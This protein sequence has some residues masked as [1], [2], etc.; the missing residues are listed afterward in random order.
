MEQLSKRFLTI[1]LAVASLAGVSLVVGLDASPAGAAAATLSF[2]HQPGGG[3]VNTGWASQPS[4]TITSGGSATDTIT[5]SITGS[6]A[7]VTLTC[8]G[9]DSKAAVASVAA[10]NG[11]A[12]NTAGTYTLTATDT[13]AGGPAQVSSPFTVFGPAHMLAFTT[14]P[15][16]GTVNLPLSTQPVVDVEDVGGNLVSSGAGSTDSITLS[17]TGSPAGVTLTC[18]DTGINGDTKAAVNGVAVFSGC[19][20]NA[21][22][23]DFTL[24]AT[25]ATN[26]SIIFTT[27]T[28]F[29]VSGASHLAFT[30]EP[31]NG[32]LGRPLFT[33][34]VVSLENASNAVV[35]SGTGSTD[36]V[37]LSITGSP[38][39]ATLTCAD[40]GINGDTKA[41]V[42]GVA[43]FSGC[44]IN[45]AGTNYTLT[46]TDTTNGV[47]TSATSTPFSVGITP[48]P[49]QISG[50]DAIGTAIAIS[51]AE[52]PNNG[53]AGG[54]VLAR[55]DFFSDALTGG[56]LAAAIN[57]PLLITPGA[58]L[59]ASLDP[60]VDAEIERVLPAGGT[61][62]V[63]GGDLALSPNIDSTLTGQGYNVIREA[64]VDEFATAVDVAEALGNPSTVFE[65]TG[66]SFYDALSAVPAAIEQ[67]AAILLTNGS[68][69][70]LETYFYLV[71]NPGDTRYAIGGPLAAYGADPSAI[72]VY[73]QDLFGTSAQVASTFFPKPSI[74]GAATAASFPDAL[75]GG[76]FMATGG[77]MGPLLLVNPRAPLPVEITPYLATLAVGTQAYVFGGLLAVGSDVLAALQAAVG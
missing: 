38:A 45:K 23:T 26:G 15:G 3:S 63:L 47:V 59:S 77:R 43:A 68:A 64:G 51:Q 16:N 53:S 5:L 56:P 6:P 24:T 61:V 21:A 8:T 17:I 4:V 72:P 11:C 44:S 32:A 41:A 48:Y 20:I 37:T 75:G 34:P 30:T 58:P 12:I 60:R 2:N 14:E 40:S 62:Y 57:G 35:T 39:G 69:E 70:S 67:H 19:S 33:Q 54:V 25:D 7:G 27:S 29:T 22:G 46:A 36:S 10:F 52:F 74:F 49:I 50:P 18:A 66:L 65:A 31:G 73:G 1:A 13:T 76:V 42:N 28:T 71:A 9:G 55:S